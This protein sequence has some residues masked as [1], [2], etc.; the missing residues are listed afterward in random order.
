MFVKRCMRR[1][2]GKRHVYWQLVESY[3]TPK[4]SRHR[5]VAYLGE[6]S[7]SEKAGWARLGRLLDGQAAEKAEQL[8][9]F[10]RGWPTDEEPVPEQ[11]EVRLKD[12]TV[13]RMRDFG[14]VYLALL[15]WR[16][17]GLDDLLEAQVEAG[18]ETVPWAVMAAIVTIARF[19]EPGSELHVSETWYAQTA[20]PD[21]L[22]RGVAGGEREPAVPDA[23]CDPAAEVGHGGAPERSAGDALCARLYTLPVRRDLDVF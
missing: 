10:D 23:G 20:L 5:V 11:I 18:K 2:Q 9:L 15:L 3:R 4:G 16:M 6:L 7:R 8:R 13:G 21:L 17:L 14:E 12:L 19:L 22:L 1:K